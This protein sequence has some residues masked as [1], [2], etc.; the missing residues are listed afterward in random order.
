MLFNRYLKKVD[1]K[2]IYFRRRKMVKE[3]YILKREDIIM[4]SGKM[5]GWK[6]MVNFIMKMDQ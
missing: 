2:D 1:T 5:I 4:V 3:F 6:D